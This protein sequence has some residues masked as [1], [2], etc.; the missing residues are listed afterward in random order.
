MLHRIEVPGLVI[1]A[2]DD[3]FIPPEPF[4]EVVFP[5]Q[6]ALELIPYGGHL[7]Y[8]SSKNWLGDW[9]WL[10]ARIAAWLASHWR[11]GRRGCTGASTSTV[12]NRPS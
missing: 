9:R 6:L 7:G 5:S 11:L 3:P 1:H 12:T 10:D 4:R 2:E 8:L